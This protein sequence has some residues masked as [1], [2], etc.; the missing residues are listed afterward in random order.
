MYLFF[1]FMFF[2]LTQSEIFEWFHFF[3]KKNFIT[4]PD[5]KKTNCTVLQGQLFIINIDKLTIEL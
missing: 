1:L 5:A 3:L 2:I 4:M